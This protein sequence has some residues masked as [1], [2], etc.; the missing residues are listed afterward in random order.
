V[1]PALPHFVPLIQALKAEFLDI[2]DS[3]DLP[4]LLLVERGGAI[5][6]VIVLVP[7]AHPLDAMPLVSLAAAMLPHDALVLV[8]ETR[9]QVLR[10]GQARPEPGTFQRLADEGKAGEHGIIDC[11]VAIRV[12]DAGRRSLYRLPYLYS[13][14]QTP[15]AWLAS[16]FEATGPDDGHV[17][18]DVPDGF[19]AV[20]AAV[21]RFPDLGAMIATLAPD[22][23]IP[24]AARLDLDD[25]VRARQI[26]T[27]LTLEFLEQAGCE[28]FTSLSASTSNACGSPRP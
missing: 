14:P 1:P 21:P 10:P 15:F 12:D 18:G 17:G 7:A 8:V 3:G 4:P 16:Q 9:H 20:C 24:R 26:L 5:D 27:S 25:P 6:H 11:L 19:A 22:R 23:A 28:T 2:Q 13:G